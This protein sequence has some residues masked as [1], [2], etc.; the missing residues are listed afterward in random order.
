MLVSNVLQ[1]PM[2]GYLL[3]QATPFC[4]ANDVAGGRSKLQALSSA[5]CKEGHLIAIGS[6]FEFA[7]H[8]ICEHGKVTGKNIDPGVGDSFDLFLIAGD[9]G[10]FAADA[11]HADI[12]VDR[13]PAHFDHDV[14]FLDDL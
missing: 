3:T 11:P 13:G 2:G 4:L 8:N 9:N 1:K 7:G 5:V 14:G 6:T 12:E 10:R